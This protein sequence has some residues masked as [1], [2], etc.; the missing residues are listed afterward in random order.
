MVRS[1]MCHGKGSSA[2]STLTH[3]EKGWVV[4]RSFLGND[5]YIESQGQG[6]GGRLFQVGG[7]EREARIR[8][9]LLWWAVRSGNSL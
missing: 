5:I 1:T 4:L 6:G 9:C 7:K 8:S 2:L 3:P